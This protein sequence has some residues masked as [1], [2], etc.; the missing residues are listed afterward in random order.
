MRRATLWRQLGAAT[1]PSVLTRA[2]S[3]PCAPRCQRGRWGP[4]AKCCARFRVAIGEY[5]PHVAAS[6][7]SSARMVVAA[8][9]RLGALV[10]DLRRAG[11]SCGLGGAHE[12]AHAANARGRGA[13][14]HAP[15]G[16]PTALVGAKLGSERQ[17]AADAIAEAKYGT[18]RHYML[19]RLSKVAFVERA[20]ATGRGLWRP[21]VPL[22]SVYARRA[23]AGT[24]NCNRQ[25]SGLR[26]RRSMA[27]EATTGPA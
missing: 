5:D 12:A 25:L 17:A 7:F 23:E 26:M 2:T 10:A 13:A 6:A 4:V 22:Y 18:T 21:C 3:S 8:S 20:V 14:A 9:S 1:L 15:M 11:A 24:C 16:A 27:F 19:L